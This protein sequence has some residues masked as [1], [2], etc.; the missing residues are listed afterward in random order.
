MLSQLSQAIAALDLPAEWIGLRAV[1]DASTTY[2]V[3]DGRPE[4]NGKSTT[5]GVMVE[6]LAQGQFGYS[7]T[8]SLHLDQIQAAAQSA[9]QQ[10]IAAS[11][12]SLHP[13]TAATRPKVV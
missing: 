8:N 5:L 13:M 10:A 2:S 9:Y 7:A 6:V 3:R 12:W 11:R 4:A 1:Q